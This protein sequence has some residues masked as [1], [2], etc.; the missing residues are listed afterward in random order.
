MSSES[1]AWWLRTALGDLLA[2]TTLLATT[3]MPSRHAAYHAQQAAEKALKATIAL[4]GGE[5]RMT[6]DL[7]F[8]LDQSPKDA[9]LGLVQVDV[10]ALSGAQTAARHP[11]LDDLEYDAAAAADLVA[12]ATRLVEAV[13]DYLERRHVPAKTLMPT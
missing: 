4:D 11:D 12:E 2:A 6:H 1:A 10:V 3:G 7:V 8:L 9:G 5:P 13:Q